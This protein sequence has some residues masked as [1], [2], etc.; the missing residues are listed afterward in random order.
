[1]LLILESNK[2]ETYFNR[3]S[4]FDPC[5]KIFNEGRRDLVL[6]VIN[7]KLKHFVI[8]FLAFYPTHLFLAMKIAVVGGMALQ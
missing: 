8:F 3:L 5:E 1:M 4:W 6:D 7:D 2:F